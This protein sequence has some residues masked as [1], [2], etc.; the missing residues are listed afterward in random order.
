MGSWDIGVSLSASI[1]GS[2]VRFSRSVLRKAGAKKIHLRIAS[3]PFI[4]ACHFGTDIDNKDVLIANNYTLE[5]IRK[6]ANV[7]SLEYLSLENL[8]KLTKGSHIK[9]FCKGCF[10]SKYPIDVP[11][12]VSKDT[13]ETI[14]F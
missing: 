6:M 10:T 1:K 7:D 2:P 5:E 9:E 12:E 11:K 4:D 13:F 14:S 3:P 8:D